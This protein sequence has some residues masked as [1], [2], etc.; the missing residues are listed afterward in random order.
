MSEWH[1]FHLD[2][3]IKTLVLP[4]TRRFLDRMREPEGESRHPIEFFRWTL[5]DAQRAAD[6]LVQMYYP[7]EC[8]EHKCGRWQKTEAR[9]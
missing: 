2:G 6:K 8:D 4:D 3:T 7:H 1:C 9:R 5:K